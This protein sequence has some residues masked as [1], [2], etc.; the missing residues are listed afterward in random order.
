MKDMS[1]LRARGAANEIA[2]RFG[3]GGLFIPFVARTSGM[4]AEVVGP[5]GMSGERAGQSRPQGHYRQVLIHAA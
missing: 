5:T 3:A 2:G 1:S 4:S